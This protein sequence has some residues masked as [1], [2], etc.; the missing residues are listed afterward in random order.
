MSSFQAE[1]SAFLAGVYLLMLLTKAITAN[2]KNEIHMDSM[3]RLSRLTRALGLYVPL[4]FWTKPDSDVVQQITD[5]V[6]NIHELKR[7]YDKGHQDLAKDKTKYAIPEIYN[8]QANHLATAMCHTMSGP[9]H[10]VIVFPASRVNVYPL[11][12]ISALPWNDS[13]M[14]LTRETVFGNTSTRKSSGPPTLRSLSLGQS[15]LPCSRNRR[16]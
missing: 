15:S 13:F 4:G 10:Q 1:A 14:H 7:T 6:R 8:I 2:A 12:N 11:V 16:C 3:S 5:K 9:V